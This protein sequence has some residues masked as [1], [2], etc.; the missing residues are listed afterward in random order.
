[1]AIQPQAILTC[2][3][4]IRHADGRITLAGIFR[5]IA[6]KEFPAAK[7]P[8]GIYVE[9]VG[10]EGD[11]YEVVMRFPG[12]REDIVNSGVIDH[13]ARSA[14]GALLSTTVAGPVAMGFTEEG[15]Y[16]LALRSN[17]ITVCEHHF[18]VLVHPAATGDTGETHQ[19]AEVRDGV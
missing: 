1:M 6:V 16:T 3:Y 5:N 12:G 11:P 10:D 2:D 9:L 8:M 14:D 13:G 4:L 19:E 17:G 18:Q 7:D 15:T